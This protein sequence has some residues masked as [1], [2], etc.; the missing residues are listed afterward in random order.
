MQTISDLVYI[1]HLSGIFSPSL[2]R[3]FFSNITYTAWMGTGF[4]LV[5]G[6]KSGTLGKL[7]LLG[8]G[9]RLS[10]GLE[11]NINKAW[12]DLGPKSMY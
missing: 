8:E 9:N 12:I 6:L 5:M 1:W 10:Q 7:F 4:L 2:Q 11:R 3:D